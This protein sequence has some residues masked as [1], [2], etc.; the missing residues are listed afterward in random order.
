MSRQDFF[1]G[2]MITENIDALDVYWFATKDSQNNDLPS[3]VEGVLMQRFFNIQGQLP[4]W[5]KEF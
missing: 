2:K 4:L 1:E 3:Y 5:N